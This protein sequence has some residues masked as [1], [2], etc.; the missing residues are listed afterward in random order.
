MF[1]RAYVEI[2][3][4]CNLR[5]SF[6]PGTRR[7]PGRMS[8]EGFRLAARA[9]DLVLKLPVLHGANALGGALVGLLEGLAVQL[10]LT[11]LLSRLDVPLEESVILHRFAAWLS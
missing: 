2:T 6:C 5:C 7:P 10:L 4:L 1:K 3:N 11:M 8:P 9:L